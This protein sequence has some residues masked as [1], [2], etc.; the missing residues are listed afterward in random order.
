MTSLDIGVLGFVVGTLLFTGIWYLKEQAEL[1]N[2]PA[3]EPPQRPTGEQAG[4]TCR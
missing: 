4:I 1:P 3:P 2:P